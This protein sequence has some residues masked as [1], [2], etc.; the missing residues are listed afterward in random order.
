[1]EMR[2]VLKTDEIRVNKAING[3]ANWPETAQEG[4]RTTLDEQGSA[5]DVSDAAK[6]V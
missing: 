3:R 5:P 1:M 4:V 2:T 6:G